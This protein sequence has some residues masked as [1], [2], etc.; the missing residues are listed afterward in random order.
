MLNRVSTCNCVVSVLLA[1]C[2]ASRDAGAQLPAQE[3]P[4]AESSMSVPSWI[5]NLPV[6]IQPKPLT[7]ELPGLCEDKPGGLAWLDRMQASFYRTA[8]LTSAKFDGFF[9]SARFNDEYQSTNGSLSFGTLW[10]QRDGLDPALRFRLRM[11]LPQLGD[12][13]NVFVGRVD[14]EE[15]VTELRDDFDSL[16]RQF[17]AQED[18]AVLLG[19][20]YSQPA[21]G[22]G[23]VD[24]DVGTELSFP[25]DPYIKGRYR[26]TL[27]F[28]EHNMLRLRE[29]LFWQ[30]SERSGMTS[31]FDLER[32]MSEEFLVRWTAS[33]TW[34][35]NTEG[36]RWLSSVTLFQNLGASRALAYQVGASGE[37]KQ[38]VP[39]EDY[40]FRLIYRRSM[41]RDW[42]FLELRSSITW[43]RETLLET[44]E[45]N[46]GLGAAVEMQFGERKQ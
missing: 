38:D 6:P 24:F 15:H 2:V 1:S 46:L 16:P 21:Q 4:A 5:S 28:L 29:T 22:A 42:L 37:T 39:L 19:V 31:R 17:G 40:G 11:Q 10:D 13:F 23:H 30:K 33:G 35:Q 43:P 20:G 45:R 7:P 14:R 36:V 27:P 44:R 3:T 34:T 9:G 18:D 32:L 12:R 8:C 25:V 41:F 26:V